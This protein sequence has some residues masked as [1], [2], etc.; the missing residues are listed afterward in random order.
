MPDRAA[1]VTGASRGI[2]LAIAEALG[3]EGYGLTIS[4]RKPDPLEDTADELRAKGFDVEHVESS[5]ALTVA[6][7]D[8]ADALLVGHVGGDV[9]DVE[10]LRAQLVRRAL[11]RVGLARGDRQPVPLLTQG[12]GD[13]EADPPG[14]SGDDGGAVGHD[15]THLSTNG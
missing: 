6:S 3:E 13:G 4:A 5:E 7:D 1:I 15:G 10:A 9:F 14:G 2:G 11:E 8:L 12:F